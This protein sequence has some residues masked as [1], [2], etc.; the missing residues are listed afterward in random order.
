MSLKLSDEEKAQLYKGFV[1]MKFSKMDLKRP[2]SKINILKRRRINAFKEKVK[3]EIS[4]IQRIL[5]DI[6]KFKSYHSLVLKNEKKD[7]KD[8]EGLRS[9][10]KKYLY[11]L[12][13]ALGEKT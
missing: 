1:F 13:K 5:R 10:L 3:I 9:E 8:Y 6:E 7:L 2:S 11:E 4:A 12:I